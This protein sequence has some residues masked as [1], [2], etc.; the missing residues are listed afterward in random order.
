MVARS[1]GG[2]QAMPKKLTVLCND[3]S[4]CE[5]HFEVGD[6]PKRAVGRQSLDVE[7]L[8]AELQQHGCSQEKITKAMQDL[9][10]DRSAIILR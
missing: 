3:R 4:T 5:I 1:F 10:I 7:R 2:A 6:P 9:A 8:R